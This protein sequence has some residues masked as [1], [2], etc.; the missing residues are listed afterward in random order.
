V[1]VDP[2]ATDVVSSEVVFSHLQQM[3][4]VE[5]LISEVGYLVTTLV[6]NLQVTRTEIKLVGL[7]FENLHFMYGALQKMTRKGFSKRLVG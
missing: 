5:F 2:F 4:G 1:I 3:V 6:S 7:A